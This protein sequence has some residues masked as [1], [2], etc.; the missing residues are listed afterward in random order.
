MTTAYDAP[1]HFIWILMRSATAMKCIFTLLHFCI[2]KTPM[3]CVVQWK[4]K[5]IIIFLFSRITKCCISPFTSI[6]FLVILNYEQRY[7][8]C[9]RILVK[10]VWSCLCFP[11]TIEC[12]YFS[13]RGKISYPRRIYRTPM[14]SR[15]HQTQSNQGRGL[16]ETGILWWHS[17]TEIRR[18]IPLIGDHH[19]ISY[20]RKQPKEFTREKLSWNKL[21]RFELHEI[22]IV[23]WVSVAIHKSCASHLWRNIW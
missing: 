21:W 20:G 2:N 13:S 17:S 6:S 1:V 18:L 11:V 22:A 4:S 9:R 16:H 7:V 12:T 19:V 23:W 15:G 3:N 10:K 14:V 8:S 5:I